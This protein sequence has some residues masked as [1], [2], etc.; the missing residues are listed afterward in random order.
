MGLALHFIREIR[1]TSSCFRSISEKFAPYRVPPLHFRK[2]RSISRS[3]PPFQKN[4]LHIAFPRSISEKFAPYRVPPLHF[5][6][7]RS[8]SRSPAP[9][10]KN[11]LHLV[12]P[13]LHFRKIR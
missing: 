3:P 10:Q 5:R 7:I 11:A 4:S 1:S 9:F 12:L 8:I 13:S 2:I 6:K